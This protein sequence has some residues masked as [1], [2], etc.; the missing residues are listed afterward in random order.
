MAWVPGAEWD[1]DVVVLPHAASFPLPSYAHDGD[2]GM[3]LRAA[4]EDEMWIAPGERALVPTGLRVALP[5]HHE[6]QIRTRSG[7]ALKRGVV[8]A[9][10]PGTIDSP[11]R[12]EIG[13]ILLN[14]GRVPFEVV[15]R[16]RIA[17]AV[18]AP[19]SYVRWRRVEELP[20]TERGE[21]GFGSTGA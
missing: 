19:V 20:E 15:P 9:N 17:Q 16:S 3:D 7:L 2:A 11:Y 12:G 14:T 10:S 5:R 21:G 6:L 1:V 18:L 4:I 13:V 8:V